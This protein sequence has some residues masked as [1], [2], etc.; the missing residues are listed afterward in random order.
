MTTK[1]KKKERTVDSLN[2]HEKWFYNTL[3]KTHPHLADKITFNDKAYVGTRYKSDLVIPLPNH[4]YLKAVVIE[5]QGG[6]FQGYGSGGA[7]TG[8]SSPEAITRDCHKCMIAQH[9]RY[10]YLPVVT[11]KAA[12]QAA[13]AFLDELY[14]EG[15]EITEIN[16]SGQP[17]YDMDF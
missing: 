13:V 17:V 2:K 9:N 11:T 3:T 1:T 12:F 6:I 4:S 15:C 14:F 16:E 10:F 7:R 8:H 5:I